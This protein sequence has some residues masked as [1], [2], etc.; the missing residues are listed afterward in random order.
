[1]ERITHKNQLV[2]IEGGELRSY[3]VDGYELMHQ[4][5]SPGW[6]HTDTEMF[7]IIGPTDKA[8]FRV[9]VPRGNAIQDQHGLLR[10]LSYT[11]E[12]KEDTKAS[13]L[14][15]YTAGTLVANSKFPDKSTAQRLIWPYSFEFKKTFS[16]T[17]TALQ[18]NF[19]VSGQK[20]MPFMIGYH[21][22]FKL[23]LPN[24]RIKT[25]SATYS[26]KEIME[27]GNRAVELP[28]TEEVFLQDEH[29]IQI[30]SKGF[31]H[32]MC[33]APTENMICV[34]P[35]SFYPYTVDQASLH[36]GFMY[37]EKSQTMF[38]IEIKLIS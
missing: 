31:G 28:Q 23:R 3:Q 5:G 11:L 1:M 14:K 18:I 13:Y 32:F 25:A 12:K 6:G 8:G 21:P 19:T 22:A 33:W 26:L 4:I 7:P 17:P 10:E 30:R 16:L 34:E 35:I 2:E 24:A 9:H 20:D 37:L 38:Q 15:K 36:E 29:N 27:A